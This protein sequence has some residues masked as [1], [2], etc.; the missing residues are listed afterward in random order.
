[1]K[2]TMIGKFFWLP[3]MTT[4]F[5]ELIDRSGDFLMAA[6]YDGGSR[7]RARGSTSR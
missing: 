3:G 7:L 6:G 1:M 2:R 5:G 4:K